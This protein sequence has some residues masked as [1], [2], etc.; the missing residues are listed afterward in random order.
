MVKTFAQNP[1]FP[2]DCLATARR[3]EAVFYVCFLLVSIPAL[4]ISIIISPE[5]SPLRIM[6]NSTFSSAVIAVNKL[7]VC[8]A[9]PH[10]PSEGISACRTAARTEGAGGALRN[11]TWGP[12]TD[13]L[14]PLRH[15]VLGRRPTAGACFQLHPG[16]LT[17]GSMCVWWMSAGLY[18]HHARTRPRLRVLSGSGRHLPLLRQHESGGDQLRRRSAHL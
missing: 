13:G 1:S 3:S 17:P 9:A 14:F 10:Q 5:C 12:G 4:D 7:N 18:H 11:R 6:G 15:S 8:E 2:S 16:L